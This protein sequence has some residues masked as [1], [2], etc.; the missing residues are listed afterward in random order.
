VTQYP[1]LADISEVVASHVAGVRFSL[2]QY[3]VL[4]Y[5][6]SPL[7]EE[8]QPVEKVKAMVV[9]EHQGQLHQGQLH[10]GQLHQVG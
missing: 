1:F 8:I 4:G 10:H 9:Q 3:L 6:A 2:Q 7:W 5:D